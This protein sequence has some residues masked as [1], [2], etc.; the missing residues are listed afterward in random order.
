MIKLSRVLAAF[1]S[2]GIILSATGPALAQASQQSGLKV[3]VPATADSTATQTINS[4]STQKQQR[5]KIG[6][7]LGGGG[8]RG[9]AHVG[10]LK[11]L[12]DEGVPIDVVAGTSIGSVVGGFYAAGVPIEKLS[13]EFGDSRLMKNFMTVPISV[14]VLLAPILF[15]PRLIGF[16]P[17]DGLY[18]GG[19][20]RTYAN[21]LVGEKHELSKLSIPYA[22][23]VT[24]LVSGESC[25]LSKG[26]LGTAMQASTAVPGL[27]KPVE[28]DGH[29]FCDGGLINNLPVDHVKALGADF[30]IAVNIDE[31]M[32]TVP[33]SHFRKAGSVST[34]ALKIQ[35]Y[36]LDK[37]PGQMADVTIHPDTTGIS[38]ISRK[39]S[40]G[41]RGIEAGET[42]ARAAMPEIRRK[43]AALGLELPSKQASVSISR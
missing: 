3:D 40:D 11:V 20:F 37:R 17:Y 34:Q 14:R 15:A 33:I 28:I 42:A 16:H 39:K 7:A 5:P 4:V 24:D 8:A 27:R 43:L 22:A 38:L 35:L 29:L 25:R 41:C 13:E 6:L 26:D 21:N 31:L 2:A 1:C 18:R 30:I 19:K 36:N 10:V 12:L 23:V 9:A 32:E